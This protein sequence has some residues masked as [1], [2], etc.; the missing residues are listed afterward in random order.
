MAS[1][2]AAR[3]ALT[4]FIFQDYRLVADLTARENMLYPLHVM[5][6]GGLLTR[7]KIRMCM[8]ENKA[9]CETLQLG[10]D[11]LGKKIAALSGGQRQRVAIARALAADPKIILADEPTAALDDALVEVVC[12]LLEE[13]AEKKGKIV[14]VVTH[15][16]SLIGTGACIRPWRLDARRRCLRPVERKQ[17]AA[18]QPLP[19]PCPRCQ[20][21]TQWQ[22]VVVANTNTVI[23][24]CPQC[25]GIW[26]DRGELKDILAFPISI[27]EKLKTLI[28][29]IGDEPDQEQ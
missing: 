3:A 28:G 2:D 10:D 25:R 15:D 14:V 4:G 1:L 26:F 9:I 21:P 29:T 17:M 12:R 16:D 11:I 24:L 20:G 18:S 13:Q 7:E 19:A 27:V 6:S 8:E 23:D 5:R 22:Q